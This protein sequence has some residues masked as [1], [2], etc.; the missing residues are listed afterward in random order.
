MPLLG[1]LRGQGDAIVGTQTLELVRGKVNRSFRSR[2]SHR[3]T[4]FDDGK[5]AQTRKGLLGTAASEVHTAVKGTQIARGRRG[6]ERGGGRGAM[7]ACTQ[8][9][10]YIFEICQIN[11]NGGQIPVVRISK[12]NK[13]PHLRNKV[14]HMI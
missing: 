2:T 13:R 7:G 11:G 6:G 9:I 12:I 4:A 8:C 14:V 1:A 10:R 5:D 3:R